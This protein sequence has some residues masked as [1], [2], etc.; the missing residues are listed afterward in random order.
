MEPI[1]LYW[2]LQEEEEEEEERRRRE[3]KKRREEERR[4]EE[5][6]REIQHRK[7]SPVVCND[8]EWQINRC[9]KAI[10]LQPFVKEFLKVFKS[11][12]LK[13]YNKW[14]PNM[15]TKFNKKNWS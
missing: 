6:E 8:E 12:R 10:S 13:T 14:G 2:W 4:E 15:F 11:S 7:E 1:L 3:E 9:V 5:R